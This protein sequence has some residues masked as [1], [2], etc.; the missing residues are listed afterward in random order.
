MRLS[1]TQRH[2]VHGM[3]EVAL[4]DPGVPVALLAIAR[5]HQVSQSHLEQVFARLRKAGLV[6]STRGPG[7]GYT[8][9]RDA[10]AISL[11]EIVGAVEPL[12]QV[13]AAG[14]CRFA[15]TEGLARELDAVMHE[16]MAGIALSELVIGQRR[17]DPVIEAQPLRRSGVAPRPT[18]C[19]SP[20]SGVPNSVFD[21]GRL[22]AMAG[23]G[24]GT[25]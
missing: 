20:P 13:A 22:M 4:R 24:P 14:D 11:A 3:I 6:E 2:A 16:H 7:G 12:P 25:R 21:L 5:R 19:R 8:L 23:Q 18:T 17:S 9:G 10:Q 15:L 1:G